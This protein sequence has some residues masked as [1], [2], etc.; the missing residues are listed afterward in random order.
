MMVFMHIV[1]FKNYFYYRNVLCVCLGDV[2]KCVGF[3]C[4]LFESV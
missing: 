1:T 4:V 3:V 2:V